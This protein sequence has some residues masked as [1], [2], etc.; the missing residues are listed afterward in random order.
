MYACV[1]AHT[2]VYVR[3]RGGYCTLVLHKRCMPF[4]NLNGFAAV[5]TMETE[6][7][8]TMTMLPAAARAVV[9]VAGM[10][11]V[12]EDPGRTTPCTPPPTPTLMAPSS[13]CLA[14]LSR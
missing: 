5:V 10:S 1:R 3:E 9:D 8:P 6:S 13:S 2:R 14:D 7:V 4:K 12:Q 11:S